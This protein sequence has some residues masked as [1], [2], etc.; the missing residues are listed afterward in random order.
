MNCTSGSVW[1]SRL[2]A[3]LALL[4]LLGA[5]CSATPS[6]DIT[7]G[8]AGATDEQD[9][10]ASAPTTDAPVE[11]DS[12]DPAPTSEPDQDAPDESDA[13][14]TDTDTEPEPDQDPDEDE[15]EDEDPGNEESD[16][17]A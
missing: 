10:A 12:S 13:A 4:G 3:C 16:S 8:T 2:V 9:I 6:L 17:D 11:T 7:T 15:D 1:R 5:A 14:D